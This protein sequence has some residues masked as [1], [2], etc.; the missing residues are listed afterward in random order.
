[1]SRDG[2]G[3][4]LDNVFVE[5]LWRSVKYEEIYLKEYERVPE[6]MSGLATYFRFYDEDRPHQSLGYRTPAEVY[7]AGNRVG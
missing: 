7:R 2:Q 6:L 3:R 4:A 1:V 5:R